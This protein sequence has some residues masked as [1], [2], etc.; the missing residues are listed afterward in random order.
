MTDL[1]SVN[2]TSKEGKQTMKDVV[3]FITGKY[4][5]ESLINV[6]DAW[7]DSTMHHKHEVINGRHEIVIKHDL[8]H[9]WSLYLKNVLAEVFQ[10]VCGTEIEF[11][12]TPN[13][14]LF[15]CDI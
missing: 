12:V 7:L 2:V 8:G 9:A 15:N 11:Q 13:A 1:D 10:D 3:L 5:K 14:L 4:D 6:I